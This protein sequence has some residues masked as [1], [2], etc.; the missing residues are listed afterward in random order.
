MVFRSRSA[1]LR[2]RRPPLSAAQSPA[3][4]IPDHREAGEGLGRRSR[5]RRWPG[6]APQK[7]P[8][9][10]FG[11]ACCMRKMTQ[12]RPICFKIGAGLIRIRILDRRSYPPIHTFK[13]SFYLLEIGKQTIMH[14]NK[15]HI[16]NLAREDNPMHQG[17]AFYRLYKKYRLSAHQIMQ[18]MAARSPNIR[19]QR[20]LNKQSS[21]Y[22]AEFV[23]DV[24]SKTALP[25]KIDVNK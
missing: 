3:S 6:I 9:S 13:C 24:V 23:P 11:H 5:R 14:I 21:R 10:G 12:H 16:V 20:A 7:G 19:F 25:F 2:R 15:N 1:W 22:A 17:L 4:S 18:V 8:A